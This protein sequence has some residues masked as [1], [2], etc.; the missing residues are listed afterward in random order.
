MPRRIGSLGPRTPAAFLAV[1]ALGVVLYVAGL[2]TWS[3]TAK[4][5]GV[6]FVFMSLVC[7]IALLLRWLML[8]DI[9]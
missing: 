1:F 4:G 2:L 8:R 7:T 3:T 5:V 6:L 9:G